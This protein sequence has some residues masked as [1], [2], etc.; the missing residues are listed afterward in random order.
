MLPPFQRLLDEHA[1][2]VLRFLVASVG[3]VDA[4]DCFQETVIAALR[5]YP[6]LRHADN[7]RGWLLTI[8]HRKA[9]DHHRARARQPVPA[10]HVDPGSVAPE[11]PADDGLWSAV[12]ELP[13]KQ[14]GA[15]LLRFVGDLSHREIASA[16]GSSE[17]AARRALADG[18][19]KLRKEWTPA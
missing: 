4:D 13:P 6:R 12:H 14:R 7:L 9:L 11:Q 1:E 19:A 18:L 3:P 15:V 2:I 16:L 8:A 10:E 17:E 5:A